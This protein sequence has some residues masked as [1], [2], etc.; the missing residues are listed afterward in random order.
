MGLKN[1]GYG[2]EKHNNLPGARNM[3]LKNAGYGAEKHKIWVRKTHYLGPKDLGP[4]FALP[5]LNG[6]LFISS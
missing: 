5:P 2:A 3:G 4:D 1:A 6:H